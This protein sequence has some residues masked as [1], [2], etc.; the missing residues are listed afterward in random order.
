MR[1]GVGLAPAAA[2]T[3]C[4][5]FPDGT[6][7]LLPASLGAGV[8]RPPAVCRCANGGAPC[9]VL[10]CAGPPGGVVGVTGSG[11]GTGR[12]AVPTLSISPA[13][14][15]TASFASKAACSAASAAFASSAFARSSS[16]FAVA[17]AFL[18]TRLAAIS[19]RRSTTPG[20]CVPSTVATP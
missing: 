6:G 15:R 3:V 17:S 14:L 11:K 13:R 8:L 16:A 7:L 9:G 4:D 19:S 10:T 1:F 18:L 20:S 5:G 2:G 12:S